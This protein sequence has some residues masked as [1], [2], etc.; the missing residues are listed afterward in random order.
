MS[1][2]GQERGMR[3]ETLSPALCVGLGEACRIYLNEMKIIMKNQN[4]EYVF[5]RN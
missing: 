2:G 4:S 1:G 5:R 3:S